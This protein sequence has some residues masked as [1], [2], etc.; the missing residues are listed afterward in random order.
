MGRASTNL[1]SHEWTIEAHLEQAELCTLLVQVFDGLLGDIR[2]AAHQYEHMLGIRRTDVVKE[3][4]FAAGDLADLF[5]IMLDNAGHRVIILVGCFTTLE[6]DVR[7]LRRAALMRMFRIQRASAECLDR[8]VIEQFTHVFVVDGFDLL[9][10]VGGTEAIE[11]MKER[12][13][14]LDRGKMRNQSKGP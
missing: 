3:V 14:A 5:H 8:I 6:I 4:V 2:A 12:N 9:H 7:V 1:G 11:E 10:F 13:A